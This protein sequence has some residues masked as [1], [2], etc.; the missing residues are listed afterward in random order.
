MLKDEFELEPELKHGDLY[1]VKTLHVGHVGGTL[2]VFRDHSNLRGFLQRF[3]Q[4]LNIGPFHAK[5]LEANRKPK[6]GNKM[7]DRLDEY[8][9][10]CHVL[11]N[12]WL[13]RYRK[14]G[15]DN[16]FPILEMDQ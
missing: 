6:I 11:S 7:L 14:Q 10:S 2:Y 8:I 4:R 15:L 13:T 9:L 16:I 5:V 3:G 1:V 12:D